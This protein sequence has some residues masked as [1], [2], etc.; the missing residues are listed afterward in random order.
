LPAGLLKQ[1]SKKA[2]NR[3]LQKMILLFMGLYDDKGNTLTSNPYN[4]SL[5][6]SDPGGGTNVETNL[7]C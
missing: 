3:E 1:W 6:E 2:T 7:N 5:W 4:I